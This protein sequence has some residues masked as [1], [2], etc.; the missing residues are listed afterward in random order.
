MLTNRTPK[1]TTVAETFCTPLTMTAMCAILS[2]IAAVLTRWSFHYLRRARW[3]VQT[4]REQLRG[5]DIE[6]ARQ[7]CKGNRD[8]M[9]QVLMTTERLMDDETAANQTQT[10]WIMATVV[11]TSFLAST[12][13]MT[14]AVAMYAGQLY[15]SGDLPMQ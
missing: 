12:V 2:V 9:E 3:R 14:F 4:A 8:A 5:M 15:L 13:G 1:E 6:R 11:A 10:F 7:V